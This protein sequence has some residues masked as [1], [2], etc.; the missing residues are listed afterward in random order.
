M[1][2]KRVQQIH[3]LILQ[4][5]PA[6]YRKRC[7]RHG[8]LHQVTL[9]CSAI[10]AGHERRVRNTIK[11]KSNDGELKGPATPAAFSAS[12][13]V[14]GEDAMIDALLELLPDAREHSRL[15]GRRPRC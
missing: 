10:I 12:S 1:P 4:K 6:R 13:F 15:A 8:R 3:D 5:L 14:K 11:G 7:G 2:T 9:T